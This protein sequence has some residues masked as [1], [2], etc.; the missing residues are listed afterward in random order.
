MQKVP[1]WNFPKISQNNYLTYLPEAKND[2]IQKY[3]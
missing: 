2:L 3:Y 1:I